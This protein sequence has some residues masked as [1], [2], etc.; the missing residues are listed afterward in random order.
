MPYTNAYSY[1]PYM[2][3][4]A[5]VASLGATPSTTVPA[6]QTYQLMPTVSIGQSLPDLLP[7]AVEGAVCACVRAC[8]LCFVAINLRVSVHAAGEMRRPAILGF[9]LFHCSLPRPSF[10]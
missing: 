1:Y 6:S 9:L 2:S 5:G 3:T 7:H 8:C 4:A 10:S